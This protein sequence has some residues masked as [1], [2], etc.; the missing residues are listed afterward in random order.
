MTIMIQHMENSARCGEPLRLLS[1]NGSDSANVDAME[2]SDVVAM[3]SLYDESNADADDNLSED[4]TLSSSSSYRSLEE[5]DD[6]LELGNYC[7]EGQKNVTWSATI[8]TQTNYRLRTSDE[9]K[10]LLHYT[11]ADM[12]RFRQV[13]KMQI[14]AAKK[15]KLEQ[16]KQEE[17]Q[18]RQQED[19]KNV[20]QKASSGT[21]SYQ[22]PFSA[23]I[24]LF[25]SQI[26]ATDSSS[27]SAAQSG[28]NP[29]SRRSLET[30][31]LID[32]LY[33]F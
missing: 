16:Q 11:A 6:D 8:V 1:T 28:N 26:P 32:T 18:R 20:I 31:L 22:N 12:T 13:Y 9:E 5:F 10:E 24:N 7:Y 14:K 27:S 4:D 33:L 29:T 19:E 3:P 15:L 30:T 17:E 21:N 25:L 2:K 23:F